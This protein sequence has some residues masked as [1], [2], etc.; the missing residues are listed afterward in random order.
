MAEMTKSENKVIA[1]L[2]RLASNTFSNHG[3]NDFTLP[4]TEENRN[5]IAGM[6][7]WADPDEPRPVRVSEG[8]IWVQDWMLMDYMADKLEEN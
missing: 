1:E 8:K 3:C 4:D 7:R 6:G 2:L 5:I